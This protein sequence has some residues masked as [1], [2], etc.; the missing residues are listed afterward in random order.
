MA[1]E[2]RKERL[3]AV[4]RRTLDEQLSADPASAGKRLTGPWAA[5]FEEQSAWDATARLSRDLFLDLSG[6]F[7]DIQIREILL[8]AADIKI[9]RTTLD[10]GRIALLR[11][12]AERH[13]FEISA[14]EKRVIL[15][16]DTGK[17]G[18]AN[19]MERLAEPGE[20]GAVSNVYVASD[21]TLAE[22]GRMVD[23]AC[24]DDLFGALL[25]IPACCRDAFERFK[26][27]AAGK[28]NDFLPFVLDNTWGDMPYD[29]RLNYAAQY[30]GSSLLSFFPCSFRCPAAAAVAGKALD[31]MTDCAPAWA[32]RSV[33]LQ[34]TNVLYTEHRGV[35]LF[36]APLSNDRIAYES[37][38]LKSSEDTELAGLLRQ[39][40][41]LNIIGKHAV[42]VFR[43]SIQIGE[44]A[45]EDTC[46]C[47]FH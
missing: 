19:R 13:G 5:F 6:R 2:T 34:K 8:A 24:E 44:V 11:T 22:T 1:V 21:M 41:R 36:M 43:G 45:G 10:E 26:P 27:L 17:G 37:R 39:G 9:S 46:F 31:M 20:A 25:G 7:N 29:W 14:G 3:R 38:D 16:A 35:H 40:D 4:L 33:E 42:H 28:Q 30:F 23:E 18:W 12:I 15:R 32:G 47:A